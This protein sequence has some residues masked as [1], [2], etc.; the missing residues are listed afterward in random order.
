MDFLEEVMADTAA[1]SYNP[2]SQCH[3]C[4]ALGALRDDDN[5]ALADQIVATIDIAVQ[6]KALRPGE[7]TVTLAAIARKM[8]EVLGSDITHN[9]IS[10]HV[11][12]G[13]TA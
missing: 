6:Q 8:N 1:T 3:V 13:H 2:A 12:K 9:S 7:R 5:D 10:G 4:I 11:A